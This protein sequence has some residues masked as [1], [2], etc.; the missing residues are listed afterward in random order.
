LFIVSPG[1][2]TLLVDGGGA[3]GGF[4]G[5]EA[6][7][8]IDP[9]EEA[10]SPYVWSRGFQ[11]LDVVAL[12]HAHQDHLGGLTAV[13]ENFRIGKLWVGREVSSTALA[14]LEGVAS[15][16]KIPIERELRGKSFDWDGVKG[17]FLWPEIERDGQIGQAAKN[18][19]SLVLRLSYRTRSIMLPGDA[20]RQAEHEIVAESGPNILHSDVLKIGHHGSKNS[21]TPEFLSEVGPR[22]GI[23]S[24]GESNPYGHP[25]P[26]LLERLA[27]AGVRILRTDRDGAVHVLTDGYGLEINCFVACPEGANVPGSTNAQMPNQE[28]SSKKN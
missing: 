8:G 6:S 7:F 26:E 5:R 15:N 17:E 25:S 19:D 2:K 14:R 1:G 11:K 18:D 13:L 9:G 22:V 28:H 21:T 16:Q 27:G 12:T 20:E 24:V 23:I 4:A 3:F 10:V